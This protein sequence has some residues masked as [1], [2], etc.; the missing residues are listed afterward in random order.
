MQ[1]NLCQTITLSAMVQLELGRSSNS[2]ID[3]NIVPWVS[4]FCHDYTICYIL[5]YMLDSL[6]PGVVQRAACGPHAANLKDLCDP[7]SIVE[8]CCFTPKGIFW[9]SLDFRYETVKFGGG[10][11]ADFSSG[12]AGHLLDTP[13]LYHT[14]PYLVCFILYCVGIYGYNN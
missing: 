14:I 8:F 2:N 10:G 11:H 12:T 5:H 13:G 9:S 1:I 4:F 7:F 3:P 6:W